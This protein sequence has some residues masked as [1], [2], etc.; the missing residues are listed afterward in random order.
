MK[1]LQEQ[2]A[3]IK[4]RA[5]AASEAPWSMGWQR[6]SQLADGGEVL[7]GD[8]CVVGEIEFMRDWSFICHARQDIPKLLVVIEK[9]REQRDEYLYIAFPEQ[10]RFIV[11]KSCSDAE[12]AA[13]LGGEK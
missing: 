10:E 4:Q 3:E 13:I 11:R 8:A 12:L 7:D 9:L 5:D 1:S 6:E 2:L